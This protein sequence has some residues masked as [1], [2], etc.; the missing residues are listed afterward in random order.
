MSEVVVN[1][2]KKEQTWVWILKKYSFYSQLYY[3]FSL[4]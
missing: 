2:Q 4:I 1:Y 3:V